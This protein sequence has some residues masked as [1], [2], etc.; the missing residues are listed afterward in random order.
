MISAVLRRV[1]GVIQAPV[2]RFVNY[3][4]VG[5]AVPEKGKNSELAEQV[6]SLIYELHKISPGLL[7]RILPNICEQLQVDEEAVRQNAVKLLG[8]LFASPHAEYGVEYKKNFRDFLGRFLDVSVAVRLEMVESGALIMKRKPELRAQVEGEQLHDFP[9]SSRFCPTLLILL[10]L[11]WPPNFPSSY[12]H[13]IIRFYF[14]VNFNL[15]QF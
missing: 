5:S 2:S 7:L 1:A 11:H 8:Q 12:S 4:L 10:I 6:Y 15:I 13:F 14:V 3:V 9:T